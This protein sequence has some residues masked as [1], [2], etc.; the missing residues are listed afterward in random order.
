MRNTAKLHVALTAVSFSWADLLPATQQ[1]PPAQVIW[2]PT[3]PKNAWLEC[4]TSRSNGDLLITRYDTDEI[5]TVNPVTHAATLVYAFPATAQVN[6]SLGI[7]EY[8]DDVFA[9]NAGQVTGGDRFPIAGSWGV[10]SIDLRNW[11]APAGNQSSPEPQVNRI[12]EVPEALML[13]GLAVLDPATTT[14]P[15]AKA[16]GQSSKQCGRE[17]TS[18]QRKQD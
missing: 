5:W 18:S 9:F 8:E 16:L 2:Q 7:D 1:S 10:W 13:N 6:S 17:S 14:G 3:S 11:T 15:R 12:A 4:L